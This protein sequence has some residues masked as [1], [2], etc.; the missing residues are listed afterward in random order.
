MEL[1]QSEL[2]LLLDL[3]EEKWDDMK[4]VGGSDELLAEV[5]A[6]WIKARDARYA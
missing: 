6:L 2:L 3:L 1:N 5:E 4:E